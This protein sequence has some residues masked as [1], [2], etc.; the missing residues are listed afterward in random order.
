M[1]VQ[2]VIRRK[3]RMLSSQT[4]FHKFFQEIFAGLLSIRKHIFVPHKDT[5]TVKEFLI[6]PP[7]IMIEIKRNVG[8]YVL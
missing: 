7:V 3:M 8:T 6:G 2:L 5:V 1:N 4:Y